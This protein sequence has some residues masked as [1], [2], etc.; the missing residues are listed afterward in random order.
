MQVFRAVERLTFP[1]F[2]SVLLFFGALGDPVRKWVDGGSWT[3]IIGRLVVGLIVWLLFEA[4]VWLATNV[5]IRR[6][7]TGS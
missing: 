6:K 4:I 5:E 7:S 3:A 2:I 1:Q